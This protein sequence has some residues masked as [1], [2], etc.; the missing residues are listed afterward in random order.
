MRNQ[1]LNMRRL[2]VIRVILRNRTNRMHIDGRYRY[3]DKNIKRLIIRNWFT[4]PWS[5]NSPKVC[6]W[7]IGGPRELVV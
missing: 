7:Q 5:L 3:I 6:S 2:D 4:Q 1:V